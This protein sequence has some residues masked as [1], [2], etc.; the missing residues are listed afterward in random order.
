MTK[1]ILLSLG[2]LLTFISI[3]QK[4]EIVVTKETFYEEI[5]EGEAADFE[6][7]EVPEQWKN[8]PIV[9]L[10]Q[11]I[12]ISLDW[13]GY[14]GMQKALV[15]RKRIK[16]Q[17]AS[18]L[19]EY[20]EFYY[21]SSELIGV[22]VIKPDGK[23]T[24]IDL[25]NA[26]KVETEVPKLY[27][28]Q[29]Q[30][31]KYF[32]VAI[33]NLEVGDIVDFYKVSTNNSSYSFE[34]I[35][36]ISGSYPIVFQKIILDYEKDLRINYQTFNDAP[37]FELFPRKGV[38]YSNATNADVHRYELLDS[39][40]E[41]QGT[42]RWNFMNLTEPTIKLFVYYDYSSKGK[43][44]STYDW[45]KNLKSM[46]GYQRNTTLIRLKKSIKKRLKKLNKEWASKNEEEKVNTIYRAIRYEFIALQEDKEDYASMSSRYYL[47]LFSNFLVEYDIKHDLVI[48][49]PRYYGKI[50]EVVLA[51]EL[52]Y[53]IYL[54][55]TD[56]YY[57][58]MDNYTVPGESNDRVA[59][60]LAFGH[61][62]TYYSSQLPNDQ[63]AHDS[64]KIPST[65]PIENK[66]HTTINISMNEDQSLNF[67]NNVTYTGGYKEDYSSLFLANTNYFK[68]EGLALSKASVR[69]KAAK[70]GNQETVTEAQKRKEIDELKREGIESTI[71]SDFQLEELKS[72]NLVS[73][74]ITNEE[75]ALSM[76][77]EFMSKGYIKKAGKN[78]VFELGSLISGQ[79]ELT[80]E[81]IEERKHDVYYDFAR[82]IQ[83]DITFEIP[84]GY[85]VKGLQQFNTR[86]E[87]PHCAFISTAKQEGNK[88]LVSTTKVY[89]EQTIPVSHWSDLVEM[90]EAAYNFSQK[91]VILAKG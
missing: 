53:G 59:G 62:R 52:E 13:Q 83:N 78:L 81:E 49:T 45:G 67:S 76:D 55:S 56:K 3:A 23:S 6:V 85:V 75:P 80:E 43:I 72:Y 63:I 18:A 58:T 82:A 77:Y 15:T 12:F 87:H 41:A 36:Q 22:T 40:R 19:E 60:S 27:R 5:M 50:G 71:K 33:P 4:D 57:W 84:E 35:S 51:D 21:Q 2:L 37:D 20:S 8:E 25:S 16:I 61:Q 34:T 44:A 14:R 74:G 70:K 54:P 32:K 26:V 30:S 11:K 90:L 91:K 66:S 64:L 65:S 38:A 28:N 79:V 39:L 9:V 31:D 86:V 1:Y 24:E 88:L 69:A 7:T 17:D 68:E 48:A 73:K 47:N 29:F 10:C 89:R 42:E 46:V